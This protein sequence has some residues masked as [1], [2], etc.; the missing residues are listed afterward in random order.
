MR[1][2]LLVKFS[3][4]VFG[5]ENG[6]GIKASVL[7]RIAKEIKTKVAQGVRVGLVIGAGFF[8]VRLYQKYQWNRV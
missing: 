7:I 1:N 2:R 3:G 5:G 6:Q 8:V 4:E